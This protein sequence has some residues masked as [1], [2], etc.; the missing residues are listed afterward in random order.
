[1]PGG[2][3][4]DHRGGQPA[5][6]RLGWD[7]DRP[8][9]GV[10]VDGRGQRA[11]T[12][13]GGPAQQ[14]QQDGF[15]QELD[16]D[17]ASGGPEGPAQPDL[18]A[19]FQHGDHHDVRDPH[20]TDQQ[21][22]RAQAE[23][24]GVERAGGVE[25]GGQRGRGLGHLHLVGVLRVG[26]VGE[27][28]V[29]GVDLAGLGADVDGGRVPVEAQVGLGGLIPDQD[30]GVD[31]GGQDVGL[32]DPGDVEPHAAGA[33]LGDPDLLAGPDP[34]NAQVRGC[35]GAE[36]AHR[37]AGGGG[38]Q[39]TALGGGGSGGGGQAQA[40]GVD[41]QAVGV[42]RVDQRG[43]VGVDAVAVEAADGGRG[44]DAGDARQ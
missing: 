9:L 26:L 3:A 30:R 11:G 32:E 18:A 40:G 12:D 14:G 13:S 28:V 22:D 15:G 4:D 43:A 19:A 6:P 2:G 27:Q 33:G 35:G 36:H 5:G 8:A 10:G 7:H 16:A 37:L 34:V 41:R 29:H 24:Q 20:G 39:E 42:D 44:L 38:V 21:R 25:L 23:E 17:L 1:E 31:L